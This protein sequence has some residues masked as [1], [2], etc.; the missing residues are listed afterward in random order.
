MER[1]DCIY[2]NPNHYD[3]CTWCARNNK[4]KPSC[5]PTAVFIIEGTDVRLEIRDKTAKELMEQAIFI[6]NNN[7]SYR[8][9]WTLY[10]EDGKEQVGDSTLIDNERFFICRNPVPPLVI[11]QSYFDILTA[12]QKEEFM[13]RNG[14]VYGITISSGGSTPI[15]SVWLVGDCGRNNE[16]E[17]CPR[18]TRDAN[19]WL[20][21]SNGTRFCPDCK[22][23]RRGCQSLKHAAGCSW[24]RRSDG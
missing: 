16:C 8:W 1:P 3:Y 17:G 14:M 21:Y 19:G 20:W 22:T 23:Q 24:N 12:S 10:G 5:K 4:T 2:F 18:Y 7:L 6:T 15:C 11:A 13:K 9:G